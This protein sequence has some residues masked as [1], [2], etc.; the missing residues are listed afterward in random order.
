MK[1]MKGGDKE[2]APQYVRCKEC[3]M[4]IEKDF[5]EDHTCPANRQ[6]KMAAVEF[7]TSVDY[8]SEDEIK[9]A[10]KSIKMNDLQTED[11]QMYAEATSHSKRHENRRQSMLSKITDVCVDLKDE[12]G[13]LSELVEDTNDPGTY[14]PKA[15]VVLGGNESMYKCSLAS[16]ILWHVMK[17]MKNTKAKT[18]ECPYLQPNTEYSYL[19]SVLAILK[20]EFDWRY[21]FETS[22][23]FKGGLKPRMELLHDRRK[24]EWPTYG[25]G[26]NKQQP[27]VTDVSEVNLS[28]FDEADIEQHQQ[29]NMI[30]MGIH[31]ALRGNSEHANLL[32]SQLVEGK[33]DASHPL[34]GQ[35][36][37][38][39][40]GL[41]DKAHKITSTTPIARNTKNALR[42]PVD[43]NDMD[44]PGGSMVR[45]KR[46]ATPGQ[47]RLYTYPLTDAQKSKYRRNGFPDAATQPNKPIGVNK[48]S[49]MMKEACAKAGLNC[50]GHGLRAIA[51]TTAANT[52]GL[53]EAD[54]LAFSRH[55]SISAQ[56]AYQRSSDKSEMTRLRSFQLIDNDSSKKRKRDDDDDDDDASE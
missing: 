4:T 20:D 41:V 5:A 9:A 49:K 50:M 13:N 11:G 35:H 32:I 26:Q 17:D 16:D 42:I 54:S 52:A 56:K 51:I 47:K 23:S 3:G 48:I 38:K 33:Y 29:K 39:L 37:I 30:N 40:T 2:S 10:S 8:N 7:K 1:K 15:L 22:F 18:G 24:N 36:F 55:T 25:T 44:S 27:S 28:M 46:K 45:L 43:I 21:K 19:R 12:L 53:P 6:L 34:A 31:F 14:I